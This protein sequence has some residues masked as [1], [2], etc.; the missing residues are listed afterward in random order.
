MH[1]TRCS[2]VTHMLCSNENKSLSSLQLLCVFIR[3]GR[4]CS[5]ELKIKAAAVARQATTT[6]VMNKKMQK[7]QKMKKKNF[8]LFSFSLFRLLGLYFSFLL[9]FRQNG[10]AFLNRK[11]EIIIKKCL[12]IYSCRVIFL[13]VKRKRK[14]ARIWE[15]NE[16]LHKNINVDIYGDFVVKIHKLIF[17]IFEKHKLWRRFKWHMATCGN[18]WTLNCAK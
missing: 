9:C 18:F 8:L 10:R 15:N 5:F 1:A 16:R 4:F 17:I 3:L 12:Q 7:S 11:R 13:I 2:H 6:R 14:C